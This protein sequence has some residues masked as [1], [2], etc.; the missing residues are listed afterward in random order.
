ADQPSAAIVWRSLQPTRRRS[1]V[2][3]LPAAAIVWRTL[4]QADRRSRVAG[5]HKKC[6]S[7][8]AYSAMNAVDACLHSSGVGLG[9]VEDVDRDTLS[10]EEHG[11]FRGS[12]R[13]RY[14]RG[15][16]PWW[17]QECHGVCVT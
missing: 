5:L 13:Q 16:V 11:L 10:T 3:G 1:H 2:A 12:K 14:G 17:F 9:N 6:D 4:Q 7:S 8:R 15:V